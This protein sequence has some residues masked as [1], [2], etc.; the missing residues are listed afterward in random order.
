MILTDDG[1]GFPVADPPLL[2]DDLGAR[3]N[4]AAIG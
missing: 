2:L 3:F 1:V 4:A